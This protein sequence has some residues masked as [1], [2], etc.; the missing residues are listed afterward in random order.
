MKY[1]LKKARFSKY[2]HFRKW[3]PPK[4]PPVVL[5]FYDTALDVKRQYMLKIKTIIRNFSTLL[6]VL[7]S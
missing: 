7:E 2:P 6:D 1:P 4:I 3:I 5:G